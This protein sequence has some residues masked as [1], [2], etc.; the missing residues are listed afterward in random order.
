MD[1]LKG[2]KLVVAW[3]DT[4][5]EEERG[6][7]TVD[8]LV[9]CGRAKERATSVNVSAMRSR[10]P[11]GLNLPLTASERHLVRQRT[12]QTPPPDPTLEPVGD[13]LE[14]PPRASPGVGS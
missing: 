2:R 12:W 1:D 9:T 5:D 7:S 3:G 8:D 11:G 13:H 4:G 6:V 14:P 10:V